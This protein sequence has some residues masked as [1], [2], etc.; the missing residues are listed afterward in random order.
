[1]LPGSQPEEVIDCMG[2][3]FPVAKTVFL[4]SIDEPTLI[5]RIE[6]AGHLYLHKSSTFAGLVQA[7]QDFLDIHKVSTDTDVSRNAHQCLVQASD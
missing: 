3:M 1:M 5:K 6:S 4:T 7:L 2:S